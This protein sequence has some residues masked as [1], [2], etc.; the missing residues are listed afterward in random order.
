[1]AE[2][3]LWKTLRDAMA[4]E[5]HFDRIENMIGRGMPD[6]TYC[7]HGA[8]GFIELKYLD[9]WPRQ[10]K[11]VVLKHF[12]PQQRNWIRQRLSAEGRVFLLLEVEHPV[13]VY[14]LLPGLWAAE[15]LGKDATEADVLTAAYVMGTG[16]FP[17]ERLLGHLM[18]GA[19]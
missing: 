17:A 14:L 10:G 12:T 1:M 3:D 13:R 15:H 19:S 5:G 8:S 18:T 16:K 6:V 9:H 4:T 2:A 7:I 11:P